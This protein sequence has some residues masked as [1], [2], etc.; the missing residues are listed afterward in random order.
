M[1]NKV[2]IYKYRELE[3]PL[4]VYRIK[5]LP[6]NLLIQA[7][8]KNMMYNQVDGKRYRDALC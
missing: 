8:L 2:I 5:K 6:L 1:N 3:H 4:K 7:N